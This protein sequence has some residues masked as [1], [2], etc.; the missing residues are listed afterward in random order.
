MAS[1]DK[2]VLARKKAHA[3]ARFDERY[4][5]RLTDDLE[6]KM[7]NQ[8]QTRQQAERVCFVSHRCTVWSV[9]VEG[10][11]IKNKLPGSAEGLMVPVIYD[12]DR[13]L[14]VTALPLN[15]NEVQ[16]VPTD[17]EEM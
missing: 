9:F 8:I 15:C 17:A 12:K 6:R 2:G 4:G 3:R 13:K 10:Q 11:L 16:N 5:I 7:I 14:L 1:K